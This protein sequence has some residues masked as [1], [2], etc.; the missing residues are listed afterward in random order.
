M[1]TTVNAL[2]TTFLG[3]GEAPRIIT[4]VPHFPTNGTF[5]GARAEGGKYPVNFSKNEFAYISGP[6]LFLSFFLK[7]YDGI[8]EARAGEQAR[9]REPSH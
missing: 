1:Q 6:N 7:R 3:L 9:R 2:M 4:K 5:P 8:E